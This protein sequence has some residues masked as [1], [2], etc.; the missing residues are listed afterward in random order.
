MPE[1]RY[2]L[3]RVLAPCRAELRRFAAFALRVRAAFLAAFDRLREPPPT[4]SRIESAAAESSFATL[5]AFEGLFGPLVGRAS[6]MRLATFF[7]TPL[8]R[9]RS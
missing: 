4:R 3:L 8:S 6:E 2:L 1:T 5:W 9:R 7:L